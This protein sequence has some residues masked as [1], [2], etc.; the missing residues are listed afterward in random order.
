MSS[1]KALVV[2]CTTYGG[3]GNIASS[4]KEAAVLKHLQEDYK[5][6]LHAHT[7]TTRLAPTW[8]RCAVYPTDT[9]TDIFNGTLY[10]I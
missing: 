3:S 1:V 5:A 8:E 6:A 9:D 4:F 10:A 2:C 7:Q